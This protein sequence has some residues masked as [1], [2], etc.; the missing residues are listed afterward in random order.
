MPPE[1]AA[2]S[3]KDYGWIA[4]SAL[5]PALFASSQLE[6][7]GDGG[8]DNGVIRTDGLGFT[9]GFR[10][11]DGWIAA[12]FAG[13]PLGTRT[14]RAELSGV[15]FLGVTAALAFVILRRALVA[16]TRRGPSVWSSVI[17]VVATAT[18]TLSYPFQH[19]AVSPASSLLGVSLVLAAFAWKPDHLASPAVAGLVS[20]GLSYEPLVG[21]LILLALAAHAWA[22]RRLSPREPGATPS[23]HPL[24]GVVAGGALGLAPFAIAALGARINAISTSAALFAGS[25]MSIGDLAGVHALGLVRSELGEVLLFLSAI[26]F[27]WAVVP[28][29]ARRESVPLASLTIAATLGL[30]LGGNGREGWTPVG[31][32]ALFGVVA[33]AGVAMQEGVLRVAGAR[34]PLAS[35]SAAMVVLL[36]AAFPAITVDD[37]LA[38]NAARPLLALPTWEDTALSGLPSGALVLVSAPRLY[39]RFLAVR[40]SGRFPG[41]LTVLPTFDPKNETSARALAHDEALVPLFR[42]LAL[43]GVPQELSLSMLATSRPLT[44]ATDPRWD[45]SLT[46]HLLPEGLLALFEPEPRGG[47]DRKHALAASSALRTR[48]AKT[49]PSPFE[50]V[51]TSLTTAILLDRALAA[52]QTSE[53][54]VGLQALADTAV[55]APK[56]ARIAR[57]MFK[58]TNTPG[59]VDIHE[60]LPDGLAGSGRP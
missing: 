11:L 55:F 57:L 43:V 3:A 17:G 18:L 51:L 48:L 16:V 25:G 59:A 60:L 2:P 30:L 22:G 35:A 27:V 28:V 36:E 41:D 26:G 23:P 4:L 58:Q 45:R 40:A 32:V 20:L 38:R 39:A 24:F 33:F 44:V 54:E 10:A 52:V 19:E 49:L 37:E 1:R 5:P 56:D 53:R 21:L 6:L 42:D 12:M 13:I 50:P 34:L 47:A 8:R 14:F 9:G 7:Y 46:R 15:V 31:L 29:R